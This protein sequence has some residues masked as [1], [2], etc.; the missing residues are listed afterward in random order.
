MEIKGTEKTKDFYN[1]EGWQSAD[2]GKTV[3]GE[4]FGVK[5][6]GPLRKEMFERKWDRINALLEDADKSNVIE[7]GCGG[8][9]ELRIARV[10]DKYSGTDFSS[11]GLKVAEKKLAGDKIKAEFVEADAVALPFKDEVFDVV[12]SAHM[13]YHIEDRASQSAAISEML[14]VLRPNGRL[15]IA[16]ANPRPI[17]F[18][19]RL[20]IRVVADMPILSKW[21]R[22]LKGP[23]PIPYNPAKLSWYHQ[24]LEQCAN[25]QVFNASIASTHFNQKVSEYSG[26]GKWVWAFFNYCDKNA[27]S[28]SAYLGNYVIVTAQK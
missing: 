20:M 12:Y 3:D 8:S 15:I 6:D 14:R 1:T 2:T 11:E 22:K 5:E 9:P 26:P 25:V 13:L 21:A 23:S 10:F 17:L 28:F 19:M 27:P 16:T 24:K 18:P 7:V 4:L